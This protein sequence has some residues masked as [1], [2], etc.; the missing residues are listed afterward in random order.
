L[1]ECSCRKADRGK[2]EQNPHR[3]FPLH[4]QPQLTSRP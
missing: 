4:L 2:N 3:H 1:G